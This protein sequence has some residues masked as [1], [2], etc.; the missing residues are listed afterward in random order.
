MRA[1]WIALWLICFYRA[2]MA[3][4]VGVD[5]LVAQL[6]QMAGDA[7]K[8][9][10]LNTL[11]AAYLA[12][13]PALAEKYATEALALAEPIG[14]RSG[15]AR[16]LLHL[17]DYHFR[18]SS[19]ALG[20]DWAMRSLK[21][22]E[23]GSDSLAMA[24]AYRL[25]GNINNLGL[26]QYATSLGYQQKA[27]AIYARRSD[28]TRTAALYGS[29][30]W[31]Y[32]ILKI[33]LKEGHR[34]AD[35]GI[36]MAT[37]LQNPQLVSYN[38]NSKGLLFKAEEK[39]DSAI[40]YLEKSIEVARQAKD[41]AVIGYNKILLGEVM[42][43]QGRLGAAERYFREAEKECMALNLRGLARNAYFG[44]AQTLAQTGD[45]RG[46][47]FFQSRYMQLNDSLLS[48][49]TQQK[50][51]LLQLGYEAEKREA[52][53]EQLEN[54]KR[55][56]QLTNRINIGI[57]VVT[58]MAMLV[59]IFLLM[60]N[61][62]QRAAANRVLM[63]K[64]LEIK[65]RNWELMSSREEVAQQRDVVAQQNQSLAQLNR[66][67][68]RLFSI[69]GHDLRGPVANLRSLLNLV[70]GKHVAPGDFVGLAPRLAQQVA[71]IHD[72]LENLLQWSLTQMKGLTRHPT[73]IEAA[74][75]LQR[76]VEVMRPAAQ[77]KEIQIH[78]D[79]PAHSLKVYADDNQLQLVLRNLLHNAL[80][81]TPRYG[82]ITVGVQRVEEW[83]EVFVTDTG[84]GIS[85]DRLP[86]LFNATHTQST[87]GTLG[88]KGTGLGLILC[89]EMVEA[90]KGELTVKSEVNKG[91]TF[92]IRLRQA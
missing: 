20:A 14:Y 71:Q 57:S 27:L 35:A 46:A 84:I 83:V 78:T 67:K 54:E 18:Q 52:R 2:A 70:A 63:E 31:I 79:L 25:L 7:D 85:P 34:L 1:R 72:T 49:E 22:A 33:N 38:L 89:K 60:R 82:S 86:N 88:E 19:Y 4:P 90:N 76:M 30:T 58:L 11:A 8:V 3:Q 81:F 43:A 74:T 10:A 28:S 16:A 50:T 53:I 55:L 65:Q 92:T 44:L 47:Y 5:S 12:N 29:I 26:R 80:K 9:D 62:R 41:L 24:D 37:L 36:T 6:P 21:V 91:S 45:Y 15:Q 66:T 56:A 32:A 23:A 61:S 75:L 69:I 39:Y 68:D 40:F 87:A 77:E 64:N 17:G 73:Q 42:L 13:Q 59:I 51:L 48:W